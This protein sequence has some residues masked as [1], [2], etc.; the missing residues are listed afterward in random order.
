LAIFQA[1]Y[2]YLP[3]SPVNAKLFF[4]SW[5]AAAFR[6]RPNGLWRWKR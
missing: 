5:K 3:L 2:Y 4:K 6:L 1:I